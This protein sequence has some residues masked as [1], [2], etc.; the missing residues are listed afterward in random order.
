MPL[1]FGEYPRMIAGDPQQRSPDSDSLAWKTLVVTSVALGCGVLVL[2][3]WYSLHVLLLVFAGILAAVL[4]QGLAA[5]VQRITSLKRGWALAIVLTLLVTVT[6]LLTWL[7]LPT[8]LTQLG[9]LGERLPLA[10]E[11]LKHFLE[12]SQLGATVVQHLPTPATVRGW[13]DRALGSIGTMMSGFFGGIV[14]M[15]VIAFV[16]IYIAVEPQVYIR[17]ILRLVPQARRD[18]FSEVLGAIGYTLKWW[19]IGQAVDMAALGICTALG[20]WLIGIPLSLLI[21]VLAAIFNFIPNIGPIFSLVPAI[22]LALTVSPGKVVW[23]LLLYVVLQSL[24]GY[25]LQPMIQ[26]RAVRL[27]GAL[28]IAA[29]VLFGLLGGIIG[30][31][32]ATPL[33]AAAFV[34]IKML[35]VE[36]TLGDFIS[37]PAHGD[38][39]AEVRKV[40]QVQ[41]QVDRDSQQDPLTALEQK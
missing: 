22:L 40:K 14:T 25:V 8:L 3:V 26:R 11:S 35:Y 30:L 10:G 2:F 24:E 17:G 39:K 13:G 20:M 19:L 32:L 37:S 4:L 21:G 15:A 31:A 33:T 23:V 9:Q 29:Q 1:D 28:I 16:G 38:A 6:V 36:D 5:L 34:A 18:R 41:R 27:P 7:T 12:K